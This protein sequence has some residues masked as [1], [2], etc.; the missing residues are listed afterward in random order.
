MKH[1]ED[2]I[3]S[4]TIAASLSDLEPDAPGY[5]VL[6]HALA[7]YRKA[8]REGGWSPI[9]EGAALKPGHEGPGVVKLRERLRATGLL[10]V[11]ES[12]SDRFD[13]ELEAAG[14]E[15]HHERVAVEAVEG[16]LLP[17]HLH[18]IAPGS[19]PGREPAGGQ[20]RGHHQGRLEAATVVTG[21]VRL[22]ITMLAPLCKPSSRPAGPSR[23]AKAV[24]LGIF[25]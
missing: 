22:G 15:A 17:E 14:V 13:G 1:L 19:P 11:S 12:V 2:A 9:P 21:G 5:G 8:S 7:M 6:K 10:D 20:G 23:V 25:A 18:G 16:Q 4:R 24:V 3:S